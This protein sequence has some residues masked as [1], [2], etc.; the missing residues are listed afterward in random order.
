MPA[1]TQNMI[2]PEEQNN[3]GSE[4]NDNALNKHFRCK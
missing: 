1:T 2:N 4:V 3:I